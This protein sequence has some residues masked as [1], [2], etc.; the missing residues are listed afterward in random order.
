MK[1]AKDKRM[2]IVRNTARSVYAELGLP[3]AEAMVVK[4]QLVTEIAELV[5]I[6]RAHV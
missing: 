4:A 1:Q 3:D 5:E 2:N 6:G